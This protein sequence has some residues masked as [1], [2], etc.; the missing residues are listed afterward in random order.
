MS[1]RVA[2][3]DF[4]QKKREGGFTTKVTFQE[5]GLFENNA[6][7]APREKSLF[8]R[9]AFREKCFFSGMPRAQRLEKSHFSQKVAFREKWLFTDA[10]HVPT[11]R[12][13]LLFAKV[14]FSRKVLF[15]EKW[16]FRSMFP[17]TSKTPA[18]AQNLRTPP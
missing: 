11:S 4:W 2:V 17:V 5:E 1:A 6:H 14:F 3:R 13:K 10:A 7:T 18:P 12:E 15:R 8:A 16:L 9:V